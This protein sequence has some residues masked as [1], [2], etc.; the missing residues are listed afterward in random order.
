MKV[1]A[2]IESDKVLVASEFLLAGGDQQ[3]DICWSTF[4]L[5]SNIHHAGPGPASGI[6]DPGIYCG[7]GRSVEAVCFIF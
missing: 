1:T 5:P 4:P 3:A 7:G 2:E 6:A